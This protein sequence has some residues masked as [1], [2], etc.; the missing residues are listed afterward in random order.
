MKIGLTLENIC[1]N[2]TITNPD[3]NSI[4]GLIDQI[5]ATRFIGKVR[6]Q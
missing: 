6:M 3:T 1:H 5:T 4:K 2:N